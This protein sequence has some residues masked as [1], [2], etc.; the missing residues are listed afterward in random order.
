MVM[1]MVMAAHPPLTGTGTT[2]WLARA[3]MRA[4]VQVARLALKLPSG[5]LRRMGRILGDLM[6]GR[7]ED[8]EGG[9]EGGEGHREED[10]L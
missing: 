6:N 7:E 8:E 4:C 1:V 5:K 10:L 3:F 9:E 2:G